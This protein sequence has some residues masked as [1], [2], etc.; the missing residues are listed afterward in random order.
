MVYLLSK[1]EQG[2]RAV[3]CFLRAKRLTADPYCLKMKVSIT[4]TLMVRIMMLRGKFLTSYIVI[5]VMRQPTECY[6]TIYVSFLSGLL[7]INVAN[8]AATLNP[9]R[10]KNIIFSELFISIAM[11]GGP[12][13]TPIKR[14]EL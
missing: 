9:V 6:M 14:I 4:R 2:F 5:K 10:V 11:M 8:A 1:K 13:A 3:Q 7:A 12:A